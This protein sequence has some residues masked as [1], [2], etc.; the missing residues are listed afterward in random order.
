MARRTY[1]LSPILRT[2]TKRRRQIPR[3]LNGPAR[4]HKNSL[5]LEAEQKP[6]ITH[7]LYAAVASD[8]ERWRSAST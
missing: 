2:L 6:S 5:S 1:F 3:R 4:Q 7:R 8:K